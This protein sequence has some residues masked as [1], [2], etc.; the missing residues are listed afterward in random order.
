M[1]K[2]FNAAEEL[3]GRYAEA[4]KVLKTGKGFEVI[5]GVEQ[6]MKENSNRI[7]DFMENVRLL[8]NAVKS[9]LKGE[10]REL[11]IG[12]ILAVLTAL[13]YFLAP[14]DFIP[15]FLVGLGYVDDAAVVGL[16]L[17]MVKADL[18][19]YKEWKTGK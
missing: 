6:K 4:E 8:V 10:Y 16:C 17:N 5:D 13:L 12:T 9:Y 19:K 18:D 15:D 3:N 2:T 11:P 7:G 1:K 14:A